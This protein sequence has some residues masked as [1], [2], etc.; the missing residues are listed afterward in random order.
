M[1][2]DH[3]ALVRGAADLLRE[4]GVLY[5]STNRRQI[6]LDQESLAGLELRDVTRATIPKDFERNTVVHRC[7]RVRRRAATQESGESGKGDHS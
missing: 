3:V 1:Q 5:F 4:H 6:R 2:R 7:W